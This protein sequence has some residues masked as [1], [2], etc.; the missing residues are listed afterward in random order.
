M[1]LCCTRCAAGYHAWAT[2]RVPP[3]CGNA[4]CTRAWVGLDP[5][6]CSSAC[7]CHKR[8][9]VRGCQLSSLHACSVRHEPVSPPPRLPRHELAGCGCRDMGRPSGSGWPRPRPVRPQQRRCVPVTILQ[10][11]R[12]S[13][14]VPAAAGHASLCN[15]PAPPL[16]LTSQSQNQFSVVPLNRI[17]R[18]GQPGVS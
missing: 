6:A 1:P 16:R 11:N 18:H 14:A 4:V 9:V 17:C 8:A 5:S 2:V 15:L 13:S 12:G 7:T 3:N 10:V